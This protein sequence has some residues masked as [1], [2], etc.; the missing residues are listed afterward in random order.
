M[1]IFLTF[2]RDPHLHRS[3]TKHHE[4]QQETHP[5]KHKGKLHF[6]KHKKTIFI[7]S[8]TVFHRSNSARLP[9]VLC[10]AVDAE[11]LHVSNVTRSGFKLRWS[12]PDPK[13]FVYFQVTVTRLRD[14]ALAVK[15][16]VSAS[17]LSVDKL[18]SGQTYHAVVTGHG[19]DGHVLA[20]HKGVVTTS[21]SADIC[22][23]PS[24]YRSLARI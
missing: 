11:E 22:A 4:K 16:N 2:L 9:P 24:T 7:V 6:C 14:H 15:T 12:N 19:V 8:G 13:N 10:S 1:I 21:Q 23:S 5:V 3:Q 20:T 17:E 18:E